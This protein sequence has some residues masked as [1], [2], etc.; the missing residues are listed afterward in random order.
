M[1]LFTV[2]SE[3]LAHYSYFLSDGKDAVVIDP[4]RDCKVYM[5]LAKK[6]CVKIRYILETHKHE[7]FIVGSRELGELLNAQI[8][9]SKQSDIKY[10]DLN[11]E[12]GE[13]LNV[14]KLQINVLYTPGH[15]NESVCYAVSNTEKSS[16]PFMVFTGD[17]L[18]I[19]SA[20]RT[21]LQGKENIPIQAENLYTSLHEKLLPIGDD[22]VIY[23]AH[24]S[25]S[26]CGSQISNQKT[27]TI[28]YEKKNNPYLQLDKEH[29]VQRA[30]T[31]N[32]LIPP[33]FK[34]MH[35]YNTTG[36]PLLRGLPTFKSLNVAEFEDVSHEIDSIIVDTRFPNAF[37]GGHIPN[38]L[39]IGL[40][41]TAVY[42]GWVLDHTLRILL[43]TERKADINRVQKHFWRIGYDNLY[44]FL[45][46]GI[47]SW[48]EQGRPLS[49]LRTLSVT[50]L[51]ERLERYA[52]L[53][54]RE[55]REWKQDGYIEG[56]EHVFFGH[57]D[58][59]AENIER[60]RRIAVICS[61]G[62]RAT[63][64]AS[65]LKRHGFLH[66]STV[67]GSMIAW[68]NRGYPLKKD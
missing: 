64:G 6:Y 40:G 60:N 13:T 19:G 15:T 12:D 43:V 23:P 53:D 34:R 46:G 36:A 44:G 17:T 1:E 47:G 35:E 10:G 26:V 3:G 51:K 5:H 20:G 29:F 9:H 41:G 8:G 11:L 68:K 21:D 57:L 27:S 58:T 55:P 33:Y 61:T 62:K 42:P 66:V 37:A 54:V 4:R 50:A 49:R 63:I 30:T 18:F 39:H 65:I 7:D 56:A 59:Q 38:S 52:V 16:A 31:Q 25:G 14:G 28:G 32:L 67:L 45:C 22:V 48:Q 24:G 2:K